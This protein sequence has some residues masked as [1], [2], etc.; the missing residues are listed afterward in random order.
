MH[1]EPPV[2]RPPSE[3]FSL[4]LQLSLGC[5][6]NACTFCGMYRDKKFRI[7]SWEEI[8][9]DIDT[10]VEQLKDINRIFL[11]DG[12]A[13]AAPT[14]LIQDTASYLSGMFPGLD[15]I[16]MYA[17][18]KDILGK[19][20]DELKEIRSSGIKLL[21]LGVESGSDQI[22][23]AVCKGVTSQQMIEAGRKALQAGFEL[24]VTVI[25]GLGGTELW[26]EHACETGK[27][28]TNI[29]PTYIGALTLM[30]VPNT[31]LYKKVQQGTFVI[32]DSRGIL[33][34]LQLLI[35]NINATNSVFRTNHAS[36]YLPLRGVLNRDKAT[37]LRI[38]DKAI[39][40]PEKIPL[41]PDYIRGL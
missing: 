9:N 30:V 6:H 26:Q 25:N 28:L 27:V 31:P 20:F 21:Y 18:P 38:L 7:K 22:L 13:L 35:E 23:N 29:D 5:R 40:E 24:S 14:E 11:A 4:I 3:A 2:F 17:G 15:R 1:L 8:K 10:C 32:P 34:E 39:T 41:R 12:D 33:K 19:S 16:S 36:N 37:I